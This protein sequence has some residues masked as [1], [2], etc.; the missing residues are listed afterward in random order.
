VTAAAEEPSGPL[1]LRSYTHARRF[2]MV[3]GRIA[4]FTLPWPLTPLQLAVFVG[5]VWLLVSLREVWPPLPMVVNLLVLVGVPVGLTW[6]V[7]HLRV[8]GRSPLVAL[9]GRVGMVFAPRTGRLH[10]QP[11]PVCR[12][13]RLGVD[14]FVEAVSREAGPQPAPAA[15]PVSAA[16]GSGEGPHLSPQPVLGSPALP[17]VRSMRELIAAAREQARG[18]AREMAEA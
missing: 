11:V 15:S 10:G 5:T 3:I 6:S 8:E 1:V 17:P 12:P 13:R 18:T 9:A 16:R 2:P 7:R 14:C 4:Q